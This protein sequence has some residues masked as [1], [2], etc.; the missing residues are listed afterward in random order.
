MSERVENMIRDNINE[1]L[2]QADELLKKA[3][4]A[5]DENAKELQEQ[6]KK[7][8]RMAR[9]TLFIKTRPLKVRKLP[10]ISIHAS[11]KIRGVLSVSLLQPASSLVYLSQR[12]K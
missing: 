11:M 8:L 12:S 9:E 6:A 4:N 10:T 2:E 1:A 3:A 5:S 7:K